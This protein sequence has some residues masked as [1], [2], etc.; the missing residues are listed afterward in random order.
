M[1]SYILNRMERD[2]LLRKAKDLDR[3]NMIRVSL[4]E[5]GKQAYYLSTKRESIRQAIS[6]LSEEEYQQLWP[7]LEKLRSKSFGTLG[8]D[9][10]LFLPPPA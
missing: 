7:C 8:M 9:A 6:A 1:I 10:S 4:T 3:K 5:K 2:G